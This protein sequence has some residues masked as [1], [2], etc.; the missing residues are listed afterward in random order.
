MMD[1][2]FK[3]QHMGELLLAILFIIYL[4]MGYNTPGPLANMIDTLYGK[5][6]VVILALALF[7]KCHPAI[8]VLG[9]IVAFELIR[10]S[11]ADAVDQYIPSEE[12]K[13]QNLTAFNQFPYTLEQEIVKKMTPNRSQ[14]SFLP[15]S[16]FKPL[17]ENNY[18]ASPIR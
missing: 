12:Q 15:Q 2:L 4:I 10:R 14:G 7:V 16:S 13:S 5:V 11:T 6:I 8:G 3:K 17:L 1:S 9:L 18:D